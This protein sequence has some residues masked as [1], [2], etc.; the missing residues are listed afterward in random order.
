MESAAAIAHP[1]AILKPSVPPLRYSLEEYLRREEKSVERHDYYDGQIIRIPMARGPHNEIAAN[2]L[3]AI[4]IATKPLNKRYRIF[5]SNQKV[6]L[7]ALNF[8]IYPDALV[9]CEKPLYWDDNE[10]LLINPLLIVEVLSRST[11]AYDR[12][13]K[14][15]EYKT[16]PSFKEYV[17]IEQTGVRVE[18]RFREEP[19]LWRETIVTDPD[20]LIP[21][22][23]IGCSIS[24]ADIY[25]N[26][27]FPPV[28]K[29]KRR[30]AS[31]TRS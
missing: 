31:T 25:E 15:S 2:A 12:G 28:T 24:L 3:T 6:F 20:G 17:L 14:F 1:L 27:E 8:G 11:S 29:P 22:K 13:D 18:S 16:L 23:S 10:V 5:S 26:I 9:V 4:K 19:D 7:P 21:L 30:K